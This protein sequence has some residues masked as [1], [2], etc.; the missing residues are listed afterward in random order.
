[1]VHESSLS[2]YNINMQKS[3]KPIDL[4]KILL[5]FENKWVALSENHK[6]VLASGKTLKEVTKKVNKSGDRAILLK[7]PPFDISFVPTTR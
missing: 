2:W 1:M 7:V 3:L 5:P 6:S 4:S